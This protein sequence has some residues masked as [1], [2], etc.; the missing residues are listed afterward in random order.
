MP[1][2]FTLKR[3]DT[4]AQTFAWKQGSE[5]GDPVDLNGCTAR[6][7][8]RDK[9][10]AL[11]LDASAYL[12]VDGPAGTVALVVPASETGAFP[13]AKLAFDIELTFPGGAVQ[14]TETMSL[15]VVED[16]TLP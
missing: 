13:V 2:T 15:R 9:T 12:T 16:V 8:V 5:T 4:W 7:Q 10:D 3:G 14:S 6:M 1:A 11:I